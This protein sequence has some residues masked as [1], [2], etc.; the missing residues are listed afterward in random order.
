MKENVSSKISKI[1][2]R[3]AIAI[4]AIGFAAAPTLHAKPKAPKMADKPANVVAHVQVPEG[5][6]TRMLLVKKNG[7]EY[8]LLGLD[9]ATNVAV[10]DVTEPTQ[11]RSID[12]APGAVRTGSAELNVVA[13]TL[14]LFGASDTETASSSPKEIRSLTGVTA[15]MRDKTRGLIYAINGDGL[16]IIKSKQ[17]VETEAAYDNYGG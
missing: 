15:F 13:D 2:C 5:P 11:P 14:T 3:A 1:L 4:G 9:S 6:V 7:K 16:W 10:M 12:T 8:L 17:R